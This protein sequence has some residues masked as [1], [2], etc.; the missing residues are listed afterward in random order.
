VLVSVPGKELGHGA[1]APGCEMALVEPLALFP[2]QFEKVVPQ[3]E[4][5]DTARRGPVSHEEALIGSQ[6]PLTRSRV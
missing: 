5:R 1:V 6:G 4:E 2:R 3:I